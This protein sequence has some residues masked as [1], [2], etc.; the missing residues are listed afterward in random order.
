MIIIIHG[1]DISQSASKFDSI[2][3]DW[4]VRIDAKKTSIDEIERGFQT[5]SLF[6]EKRTIIIE[7][8][9]SAK[10]D[11]VESLVKNSIQLS[12]LTTVIMY[13]ATTIHARIL[14][15]FTNSQIYDYKLP[16]LYFN[17]LDG[18]TP[19]NGKQRG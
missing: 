2:S 3:K 11:I 8:I 17:F 4:T 6:D 15:K 14:K 19:G 18:L 1:D 5:D 9:E 13:S 10:K 7:N 12:E 16:K